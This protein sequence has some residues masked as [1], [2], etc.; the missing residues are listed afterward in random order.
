MALR[1]DRLSV[2]KELLVH[3]VKRIFRNIRLRIFR[4]RHFQDTFCW[5]CQRHTNVF[6]IRVY[7]ITFHYRAH[8]FL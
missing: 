6:S 2:I 8:T 1:P 7:C 3:I 5:L 4:T